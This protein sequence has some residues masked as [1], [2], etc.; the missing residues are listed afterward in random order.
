MA[1][2][3]KYLLEWIALVALLNGCHDSFVDSE[4][5]GYRQER[6]EKVCNHADN[7]KDAEGQENQQTAPEH[8]P[9]LLDISP[10]DQLHNCWR[11]KQERI[12]F[13]GEIHVIDTLW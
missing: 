6:Q 9:A 3:P 4:A 13:S 12:C 2:R 10:V 11:G 5:D 7:G 8:H 1:N